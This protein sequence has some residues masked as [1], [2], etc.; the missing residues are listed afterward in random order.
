ML[1][2]STW[3]CS[4]PFCLVL[5]LARWFRFSTNLDDWD[6]ITNLLSIWKPESFGATNE[7]MASNSS[8]GEGECRAFLEE[9]AHWPEWIAAILHQHSINLSTS[10]KISNVRDLVGLSSLLT[11]C[12]LGLELWRHQNRWQSNF[13]MGKGALEGLCFLVFALALTGRSNAVEAFRIYTYLDSHLTDT[14]KYAMKFDI[15]VETLCARYRG[16]QDW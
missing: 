14:E 1:D 5:M 8:A 11:W 7:L 15:Y 13:N 6:D 4:G 12:M 9:S 16:W 3:L 2:V 10:L